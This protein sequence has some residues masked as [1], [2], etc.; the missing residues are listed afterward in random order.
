M[1]RLLA[2]G[3]ALAC[4]VPAA[5]AVR[6][7]EGGLRGARGRP[8]A[9]FLSGRKGLY[10]IPTTPPPTTPPPGLTTTSADTSTTSATT[11]G[12]VLVIAAPAP[13]PAPMPAG[14]EPPPPPPCNYTYDF[15]GVARPVQCRTFDTGNVS[16]DIVEHFPEAGCTKPL[17]VDCPL[18]PNLAMTGDYYKVGG[19]G[20]GHGTTYQILCADKSEP[21]DRAYDVETWGTSA[22]PGARAANTTCNNG[23]WTHIESV[24]AA[25]KRPVHLTCFTE[26]Q[27]ALLKEMIH[28]ANWTKGRLATAEATG[29]KWIDASA[30]L[31][32]DSLK[33]AHSFADKFYNESMDGHIPVASDMRKVIDAMKDNSIISRGEPFGA[34]SCEDLQAHF[35]WEL[36]GDLGPEGAANLVPTAYPPGPGYP[37]AEEMKAHLK[38]A[39][40]FT[41]SYAVQKS[42]IGYDY[43]TATPVMYYRDGCY[44]ESRWTGGCPFRNDLV[45]SYSYFGFDAIVEK[46]VSSDV[47]AFSPNSLCWYW[48]NPTHPEW[49]YLHG[50]GEGVGYQAPVRNSTHLKAEW[51]AARSAGAAAA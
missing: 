50:V 13:A 49:G 36:P 2:V 40:G 5:G 46:D 47:G 10:D 1:Q 51:N 30:K 16:C 23:T 44:C 11:S 25:V 7:A 22:F 39:V 31:R 42:Q 28:Y 38:K 3:A 43:M 4:Q 12:A 20:V 18:F 29:Y 6:A 32:I 14:P 17:L 26:E 33:H 21:T 34:H 37:T 19:N 8:P 24:N 48:S 9:A 27:I 45:P 15:E 41:C 35:L